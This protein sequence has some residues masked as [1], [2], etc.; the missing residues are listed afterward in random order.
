MATK[1]YVFL[2][3]GML[4]DAAVWQPQISVLQDSY[5][6]GL[7]DF[8]GFN[9][10]VAM[11]R[12]VLDNAPSR[13][14]VV[15]H[16]M[17]GRVAMELMRMAPQR[18]DKFVLMDMGVHPVAPGEEER[19]E[20]LL[21]LAAE[22]GLEAVADSWIPFMIHPSRIH[23]TALTTAIHDMVLRNEISD[24]QGQLQAAFERNDQSTYLASIT[25]R[26][27]VVCGDS[28]NWNPL[29]LHQQMCDQMHDAELVVIPNCG[30]MVTME[31]PEQV[32]LL[33]QHWLGEN[34][35]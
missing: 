3:P 17:G 26:V 25:H 18:I 5:T 4:C 30:H 20:R 11:A 35:T 12:S 9:S 13:F 6:L 32:N 22:G 10:L 7:P 8:R 1:P 16:S 28:D 15:A 33:L 24:L 21:E 14:S 27:H 19:N 31:A 23:D 2:L 29:H 34:A